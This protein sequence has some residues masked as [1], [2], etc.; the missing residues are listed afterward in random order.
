MCA[1][2]VAE[3]IL[4]KYEPV[5]GLEAH[6]QLGTKT[7]IFCS[8]PVEFGAPPNTNVCPVCLGLPGALPVLSRQAVELAMEAALALK[9]RIN[10]LSRLAR[11][12]YFYPDLPKGYQISQYDQPLAEHGQLNLGVGEE[13]KRIGVTRVHMEDDAGKSIHDGFADSD[14]YSYVDLNRSGT[15]LIE[16]VSDPDMRSPDEAYAYVTELKQM[17][18]YT[19]ISDCDMEKGQLRCDANVSV[20]LRGAPEF[21]TKVEV[22]NLNSFRF[23]KLA[24]EYEIERQVEIL[25]SGGKVRQE[26]RLYNVSTGQTIGMRSKERAQDYRYFPEPDLVPLHVSE[27]WLREVTAKLAELPSDRRER[28]AA[29]YGLRE[30]DAQVLALTRELGDYFEAAAKA[31]GDGRATANW[32]SGDLLGLLNASGRGIAHS[33]VRAEDLGELVA[34]IGKGEL[35]G[36]LAKEILPKMF[37]TGESAPAVMDREGLRQ[38]SDSGALDKIVDEV[39]AANPKQVEQYR[40]GKTAVLGFLVGQVMKASRGQANPGAANEAL[41]KRL[42]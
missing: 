4:T 32:V 36:K 6:V 11:K 24:L 13:R 25:E 3:S 23:L 7:K 14:R 15:P 5:I 33:P 22:K 40:G 10:E 26:T 35:S 18:Q 20:R 19:G 1:S 16:I 39:I 30:Y 34:L 27:H 17:M 9:C 2:A 38:I 29:E 21:G 41:K 37:E 8:C 42:G 31:S 12:N 28:F